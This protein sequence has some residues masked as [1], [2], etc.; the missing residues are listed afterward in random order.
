MKIK[1]SWHQPALSKIHLSP[2]QTL[3]RQ[4]TPLHIT[5]AE[6]SIL[7]QLSQFSHEC[8]HPYHGFLH[9]PRSNDRRRVSSPIFS[10][11]LTPDPPDS[12]HKSRLLNVEE[13]PFKRITKRLLTPSNPLITF[14]IL[15]PTPPPDAAAADLEA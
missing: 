4:S 5:T 8:P 6:L 7:P 1:V 2:R 10:L 14:P 11:Q 9:P 12:L 15:P 13:K 3:S